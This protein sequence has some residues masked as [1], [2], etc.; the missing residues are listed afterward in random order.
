V[1][2]GLYVTGWLKRG[3]TGI[4]GSNINDARETAAAVIEDLQL[5]GLLAKEV[6]VSEGKGS[7][8][9]SEG[10]SKDTTGGANIASSTSPAISSVSDSASPRLDPKE[11]IPALKGKHVVSWTEYLKIDAEEVKRG[12]ALIPPKPREKI[13]NISDMIR[14]AKRTGDTI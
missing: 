5:S 4:I 2:K 10:I 3:P 12:Q 8:K 14:I 1:V 13:T 9:D 6:H 7:D 11:V